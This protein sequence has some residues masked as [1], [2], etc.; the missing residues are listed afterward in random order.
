MP[1]SL[2]RPREFSG[3]MDEANSTYHT[4]SCGH[5]VVPSHRDFPHVKIRH[6][7]F[8]ASA[9]PRSL[10]LTIL[11]CSCLAWYSYLRLY[12][13]HSLI[14]PQPRTH[15]CR[16]IVELLSGNVMHEFTA[17]SLSG[18]Y[19]YIQTH[20]EGGCIEALTVNRRVT[21]WIWLAAVVSY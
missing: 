8:F 1:F 11:G 21:E 15:P 16:K 14:S 12:P 13:T 3:I 17:F 5:L 6:W 9:V 18:F 7:E 10:L 4:L 2:T 20:F 19:Q